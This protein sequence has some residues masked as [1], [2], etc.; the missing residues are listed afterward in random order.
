MLYILLEHLNHY[1]ITKC[2]FLLHE[3]KNIDW[4]R[5]YNIYILPYREKVI[6]DRLLPDCRL[7]G[8]HISLSW[9]VLG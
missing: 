3:P 1:T 6:S 2:I 7:G 4:L 9:Q 8:G 5:I